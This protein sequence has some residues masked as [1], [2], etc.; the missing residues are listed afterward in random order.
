M[1]IEEIEEEEEEVEETSEI[2]KEIIKRTQFLQKKQK[3]AIY[4]VVIHN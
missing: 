2:L 3:L 4:L 1:G